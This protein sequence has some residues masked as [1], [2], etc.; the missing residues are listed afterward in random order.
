[1]EEKL[2]TNSTGEM[3]EELI[4]VKYYYVKRV[5][6]TVEYVDKDTGDKIAEDVI[7]E[8]YKG[9]EY[10]T[11]Q[12]E[13]E[14]YEFIEVA[15]ETEGILNEDDVI[16]YY[17]EQQKVTEPEPEPEEPIDNTISNTILPQTGTNDSLY[18]IILIVLLIGIIALIKYKRYK[19]IE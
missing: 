13:I 1:M 6:I 15:G 19:N 4:E 17:Y 14:G 10:E 12:K 16:T 8:G 3:T 7:I 5:T 11:E 9:E 18:I 2:P